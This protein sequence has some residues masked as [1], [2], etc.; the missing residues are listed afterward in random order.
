MPNRNGARHTSVVDP[1]HEPA[2]Q[3]SVAVDAIQGRFFFLVIGI[4][5]EFR[6]ERLEQHI[7]FL[8]RPSSFRPP[9]ALSAPRTS[10]SQDFPARSLTG[11]V[12]RLS[13]IEFY[14]RRK[15]RA[16][17]AQGGRRTLAGRRC[18]DRR[19]WYDKA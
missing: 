15:R 9:I 3:L 11:D 10:Q 6:T 1:L 2:A 18:P 7:P 14:R 19:L 13:S 17:N 12:G 4:G 16:V 8:T 5:L